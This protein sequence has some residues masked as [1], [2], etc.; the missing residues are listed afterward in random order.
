[1]GKS[2]IIQLIFSIK[3]CKI[4]I[5]LNEKHKGVNFMRDNLYIT[6][7]DVKGSKHYTL[8]QVMKKYLLYVVGG[9]A[10]IFLILGVSVII[11]GQKASE[12]NHLQREN[13]RLQSDMDGI[14]EKIAGKAMELENLN[15]K[16]QA[17][18]SIIGSDVSTGSG[19]DERLDIALLTAAEREHLLNIIPSGNPITPFTIYT[20]KFGSRVHPVLKQ[21]MNH[22]GLDFRAPVGTQ[23]IAPADGVVKFAGRH[24]T[25]GKLTIISHAFGFE[26]YYAHQSKIDVKV[27]DMISKGDEIGKTGNTGRSSGPHL[28]YEIHYLGKKLDPINF[29]K[30]NL[31]NYNT[32]FEKEKN[33]KWQSL[34]GLIRKQY[35]TFQ[36]QGQLLSH[37]GQE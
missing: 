35:R 13:E 14:Q 33:I 24:G 30:W 23:I 7:T 10:G 4:V 22:W 16:L 18:E 25:F 11:L 5:T 29:A 9:V 26:T 32:L 3:L 21:R 1:M 28:H 37:K 27:G 20:S 2:E 15:E 36:L 6:I 8:N 31:E 17:V 19:I 12:Y 34:V